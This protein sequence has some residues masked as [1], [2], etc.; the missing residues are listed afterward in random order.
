LDWLSLYKQA[1]PA[2]DRKF[3]TSVGVAVGDVVSIGD[4]EHP[5][6]TINAARQ[7]IR[8][9]NNCIFVFRDIFG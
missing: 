1:L 6:I 3:G 7:T 5:A 4:F 8:I 2:K 9:G